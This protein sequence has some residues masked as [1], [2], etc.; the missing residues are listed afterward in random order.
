MNTP[1][2]MLAA[3]AV[4]SR[5]DRPWRDAAV[6]AGGLL[7]DI[8]IFVLFF[9]ARAQGI[10]QSDIWRKLYWQE[11]WQSLSAVSNSFPIW[12]LLLVLAAMA[13]S[14]LVMVLAGAILVH[15][16]LD[17]PVHADDAH[18]HFWPLTDW[19]FHSPLSYWDANHHGRFVALGELVLCTGCC[20]VLWFRFS[21]WWVRGLLL[22][23]LFSLGL[24]PLFFWLTLG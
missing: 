6:L 8:S 14:R 22:G 5:P 19:R 16:T 20:A 7:P 21:D 2:H 12:A 11:P 1:T 10:P 17:F 13:G 18:K 4:L 9:W 23:A 3:A 15:L 24:V